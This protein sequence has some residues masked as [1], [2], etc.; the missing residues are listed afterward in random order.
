[1]L[2]VPPIAD[3]A[4]PIKM[5]H[6]QGMTPTGFKLPVMQTSCEQTTNTPAV[7]FVT[8]EVFLPHGNGSSRIY[9][10]VAHQ[11]AATGWRTFCL[12]FHR[13]TGSAKSEQTGAA[14]QREFARFM[15]VPGW[16]LGGTFGGRICMALRE[17]NRWTT[18]NV[19]A[20]HPFLASGRAAFQQQLLDFVEQNAISEIYFH[21]PHTLLLLQPMLHRLKHVRLVADVHDDFVARSAEYNASY[22]S[23][24]ATLPF[25]EI[26]R[27]HFPMY[28]RHRLSHANLTLSRQ[29]EMGLLM[30]CDEVLVASETEYQ[31]YAD[32]AELQGKVRYQPWPYSP[33][34]TLFRRPR[35]PKFN[36]GFIGADSVMNLDA[37]IHFR[38]NILPLIQ[39]Q[40]PEFR[41]LFAGTIARKIGPL[42]AG[43][44]NIEVWNQLPRLEDFYAAIGIA[45]VPLR[46]GTGVSVKAIEA[47]SFGCPLVT[48]TV[49][50]RGIARATLAG[51]DLDIADDCGDF[52][53]ALTR[54]AIA[55][56]AAG[57]A[58]KACER[59]APALNRATAR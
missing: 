33:S 58:A 16:N 55:A 47:L 34:T 11:Y 45:A 3:P 19:F 57:K 32:M 54:R 10:N 39:S 46:H 4:R 35:A 22:N 30:Y 21:K 51:C 20:S 1:M 27:R 48:T 14:Y 6:L 15:L 17:I 25:P 50:I 26:L 24:F 43:I 37:V 7:L 18:G 29:K 56:R 59:A 53:S 8:D 12:S 31:R 38:D 9:T 13:D 44:R 5:E 40:L 23:L 41:M 36:A 52:A 42:L 28:L 2:T 49:G